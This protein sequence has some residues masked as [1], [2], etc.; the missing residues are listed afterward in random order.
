MNKM[1]ESGTI[2][3]D[4]VLE[5]TVTRSKAKRLDFVA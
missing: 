2:T 4:T 3:E 5:I 1:A